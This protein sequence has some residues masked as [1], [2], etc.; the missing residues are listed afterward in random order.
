M[1]NESIDSAIEDNDAK[2]CV[3]LLN[4]AILLSSLP[5]SRQMERQVKDQGVAIMIKR[6]GVITGYAAGIGI[7]G[8]AVKVK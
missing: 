1:P 8:H 2:R 6:G 3:F 4:M 7:L 5:K